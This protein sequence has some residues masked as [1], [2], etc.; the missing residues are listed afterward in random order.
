[1]IR[2]K[3]KLPTENIHVKAFKE[4]IPELR[5]PSPFC[6][7]AALHQTGVAKH[8]QS[9]AINLHVAWLKP[10]QAP[11]V[12]RLPQLL[13]CSLHWSRLSIRACD[14]FFWL[15]ECYLLFF[16]PFELSI[17]VGETLDGLCNGWQIWN[18]LRH[19]LGK[20]EE[21]SGFTDILRRT[22]LSD[23]CDLLFTGFYTGPW[24]FVSKKY[25]NLGNL[26]SH[27]SSFSVRPVSLN[28]SSTAKSLLSCCSSLVRELSDHLQD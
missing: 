5:L 13:F 10:L 24:Y 1:M 21:G 27:L 15:L 19:K 12:T 6:Y 25:V 16:A 9:H 8:T 14:Q 26:N 11:P 18:K 7:T 28:R 23:C 17:L 20:T 3:L 4:P 22:W 2:L